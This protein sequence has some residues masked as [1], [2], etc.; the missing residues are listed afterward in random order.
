MFFKVFKS[1]EDIVKRN[2]LTNK[3][4]KGKREPNLS[5]IGEQL[6]TDFELKDFEIKDF[7]KLET[8]SMGLH[9]F[10]FYSSLKEIT[11]I[12]SQFNKN[13]NLISSYRNHTNRTYIEQPQQI[14]KVKKFG[15]GYLDQII[16]WQDKDIKKFNELNEIANKIS[17][18][19][20]ISSHRI[21][22]G[23]YETLIKTHKKG[24]KEVGS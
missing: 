19:D 10:Q 7:N 22:G 2:R 16:A 21:K 15:E 12:F 20:S 9:N 3:N 8:E 13:T 6:Y 14:P 11:G 1:L 17:L 4:K 5:E 23:R 18:F 24:V